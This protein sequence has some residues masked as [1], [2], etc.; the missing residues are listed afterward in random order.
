M[1]Y[2]STKQS[3]LYILRSQMFNYTKNNLGHNRFN[4]HVHDV[5]KGE[6]HAKK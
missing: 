4:R 5:V 2:T 3:I 1:D 6:G